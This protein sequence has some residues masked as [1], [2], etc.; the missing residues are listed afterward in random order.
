MSKST[1]R[2]KAVI[3]ESG[4]LEE[5]NLEK[6]KLTIDKVRLIKKEFL[7]IGFSRIEVDGSTTS[8]SEDH[9]APVHIDLKSRFK[10]LSPHLGLLCDYLSTRQI[11]DINNY[12]PELVES[13]IVTGI[14]IGGGDD[15][16]GIILSGYKLTKSGRAIILNT[17]FTLI[18]EVEET[19]Y[20]Y[21]DSLMEKVKELIKEVELYLG[22]KRGEE[23]QGTLDFPP[24]AEDEDELS[25]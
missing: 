17:P 22:G 15:N 13:F 20:R 2:L 9:K 10:S 7:K 16:D 12:D 14:S 8:V 19:R 5:I 3:T 18:E 11:K 23:P 4:K 6:R 25:I 1:N 24:E 21:M